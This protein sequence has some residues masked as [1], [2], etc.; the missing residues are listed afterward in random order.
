M[1]QPRAILYGGTGQAK[2]VRE[3]LRARGVQV[4]LIV[5]DT[6]GL[7]SP[8][9]DVPIVRGMAGLREWLNVESRGTI[10]F[11]IT[12]GPPHGLVR[13]RIA[14]ELCA[15]GLTELSAIH[16][17]AIIDPTAT[18]ASGF[19]AMAGAVIQPFARIGRQCIINTKASIDHDC[20][21]ED[22]VDVSP[23][24]T[25]CGEVHIES[26]AWIASGATVLPRVV[27]GAGAVVGA[28][29]L[30]RSDV[31]PG[32]TVVGVPAA[33]ISSRQSN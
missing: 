20:E 5:D 19:Q 27:I 22:G 25:I 28:A 6:P 2:V 21:V 14:H 8:F 31:S 32:T 29:S 26:G 23:G 3:I 15:L 17:S 7:Q 16:P 4:V 11:C 24:A 9:A 10:G 1:S 33:P 13:L 18:I 12:I 30:V